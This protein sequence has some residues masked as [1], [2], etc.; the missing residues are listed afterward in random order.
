MLYDTD[1]FSVVLS[2]FT[3]KQIT[4][5]KF[6]SKS[7]KT[8]IEKLFPHNLNTQ[9]K[10]FYELLHVHS[11]IKVE[12]FICKNR[13]IYHK[14]NKCKR[15]GTYDLIDGSVLE[16]DE[17]KNIRAKFTDATN[18]IGN[19]PVKPLYIDFN[20]TIY[21]AI[22]NNICINVYE[23]HGTK[24]LWLCTLDAYR[25]CIDE[26]KHILFYVTRSEDKIIR[27]DLKNTNEL[28]LSEEYVSGPGTCGYGCPTYIISKNIAGFIILRLSYFNHVWKIA[29]IIVSEN[30]C[31]WDTYSMSYS[32]NLGIILLESENKCIIYS[33]KFNT[34]IDFCDTCTEL[35]A[36]VQIIDFNE[37]VY[38]QTYG[39][40]YYYSGEPAYT[41]LIKCM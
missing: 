7:F 40:G 4:P 9:M 16:N 37:Y 34:I 25:I 30:N 23:R 12:A 24:L 18:Y 38:S 27:R 29:E 11:G 14:Y 33:I 41:K 26:E 21:V 36:Y 31:S 6:V 32:I 20:G 13:L 5:L 10:Q 3:L 1:I 35:G 19:F 8:M 39:D 28:I 2:H 22:N 15:I 17:Y